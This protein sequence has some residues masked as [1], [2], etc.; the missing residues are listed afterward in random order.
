MPPRDWAVSNGLHS[1]Q[2]ITQQWEISMDQHVANSAW[3]H[4]TEHHDVQA[5]SR[6]R[7][8]LHLALS[9]KARPCLSDLLAL[10]SHFSLFLGSSI[11]PCGSLG[12]W[13]LMD[14]RE[15]VLGPVVSS[16]L[17]A[18]GPS[19]AVLHYGWGFNR[20]VTRDT[21]ERPHWC[22]WVGGAWGS[23]GWGHML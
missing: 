10:D 11:P 22:S 17:R 5:D 19:L 23:A 2:H 9:W 16:S 18:V 21:D 20:D 3:H 14:K 8:V 4:D 1:L 6:N 13:E 12:P 7:S 15:Y